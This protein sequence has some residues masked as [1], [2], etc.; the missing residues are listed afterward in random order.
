MIGEPRYSKGDDVYFLFNGDMLHGSVFVVDRYGT[1]EQNE[2][3]S[4]DILDNISNTLYKHVREKFVIGK[5]SYADNTNK[6]VN[7]TKIKHLVYEDINN[8]PKGVDYVLE[9]MF[10]SSGGSYNEY[11]IIGY[12]FPFKS[13]FFIDDKNDFINLTKSMV[14]S[15][16]DDGEWESKWEDYMLHRN[17]GDIA[18]VYF[19]DRETMGYLPW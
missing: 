3:P 18:T 8:T 19:Y 15:Y 16:F 13:A 17:F 9:T 4:Y 5:V 14:M 6:T 12:E 2:E 7:N 10:N 11:M 1:F